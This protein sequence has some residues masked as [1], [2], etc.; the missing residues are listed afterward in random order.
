[1]DIGS[2]C[3]Y[4]ICRQLTFLPLTCEDCNHKFC[5]HHVKNEEHECKCVKPD[6]NIVHN[7]KKKKLKKLCS[8]KKCK[9][10]VKKELMM[11]CNS[12]QGQYCI[13]HRFRDDH[14]C[15]PRNT[16]KIIPTIMVN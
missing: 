7:I 4:D 5:K 1:M 11:E 15:N 8:Y 12:C 10:R 6:E 14:G 3:H 9:K 13:Y 16:H 2:H